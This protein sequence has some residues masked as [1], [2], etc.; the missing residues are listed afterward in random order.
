MKLI[1]AALWGF[2]MAVL[3]IL[4]G[5]LSLASGDPFYAA[6]ERG[7]AW[8]LMPGLV[9]GTAAGSFTLAAFVNAALHFSL[10]W[11]ILRIF[12]R[13]RSRHGEESAG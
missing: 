3:T 10:A 11:L 1:V 13:A 12:F 4:V 2:L 9:L 6:L 7:L 8:L 5:P